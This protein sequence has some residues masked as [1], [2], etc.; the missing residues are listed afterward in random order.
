MA[1]PRGGGLNSMKAPGTR[2]RD[3][4]SHAICRPRAFGAS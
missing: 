3:G 2:L 1:G 4:V